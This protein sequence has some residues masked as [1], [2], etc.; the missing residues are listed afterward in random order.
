[1]EN[2]WFDGWEGILRIICVTLAI[3][4]KVMNRKETTLE[5]VKMEP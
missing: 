2:V 5:D 4:E 1:M 3:I